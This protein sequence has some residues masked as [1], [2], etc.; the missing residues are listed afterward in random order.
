MILVTGGTGFVGSHLLLTLAEGVDAVRAIYRRESTL[1][2]TEALF[3]L[4]QKS[5]LFNKIEWIM[6]DIND[7]PSLEIAFPNVTYVYHCAGLISFDPDDEKKLRK[8]N[9]EG[10][11]NVVNLCLHHQ[12]TKL[13]HVSSVAAL[14]DAKAND[15]IITE[16]NEWNPEKPHSDYA[17]SKYGAEI[18]IWR[19]QNEGLAVVVVNPGIILGS[20]FWNQGSGEIFSHVQSGLRYYTKGVTGY[21]FINDVVDA[22]I[23]LMHSNIDGERFV[24]VSENLSFAKVLHGIAKALKVKAPQVYAGPTITILAA[25]IDWFLSRIMGRKRRLSIDAARSLHNIDY[26]SNTKIRTALNTNFT[27]I[28]DAIVSIANKK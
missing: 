14:G 26:Y 27:A 8:I 4:H 9:I 22:M 28:D 24:L 16:E 19:G 5:H 10:T 20:G 1:R 23:K 25:R 21:V 2:K 6:G 13:C 12:I 17:I 18:E 3:A 15:K 7:I 11:S